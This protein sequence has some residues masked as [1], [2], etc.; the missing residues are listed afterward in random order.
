MFSQK[1]K[2]ASLFTVQR[3]I[4]HFYPYHSLINLLTDHVFLFDNNILSGYGYI[5]LLY[6]LIFPFKKKSHF[7]YPIYSRHSTF[8]LTSLLCFKLW[9]VL[10]VWGSSTQKDSKK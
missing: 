2:S 7:V 3:W 9:E 4:K 10:L 6:M 1:V 8:F 5:C